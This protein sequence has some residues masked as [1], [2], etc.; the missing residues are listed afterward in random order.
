[1]AST[2]DKSIN[3][4]DCGEEFLFTA[5]EQAFYQERGLTNAPTRCKACR[6]KRKAQRDGGGQGGHSGH[7]GGGHGGRGG[8]YGGGG[9]GGGGYGRS[10]KAMFATNCSQCGRE[11]E[12]PFQPTPGRPVLC[13]DCF[14]ASKGDDGGG[15][16]SGG[17]SGGHGGGGGGGYGG[18]GGGG[19]GAGGGRPQRSS[20]PVGPSEGRIGGVVKWFNDAKGF[21]FIQADSGED[22]FVHF[23]AISSDGFRSLAEGDRVEFDLVS[24][25]KGKQAAN[26]ARG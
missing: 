21:G 26:V 2:G 14:K 25:P 24:G 15:G 17:H 1:M 9:G 12:V 8:G 3:C 13:R 19:R 22:V 6:D 23:S 11:T 16:H 18:S 20:E 4:V 5:G 7:G 10:E